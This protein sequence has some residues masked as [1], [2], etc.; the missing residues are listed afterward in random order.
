MP[1]YAFLLDID[2]RTIGRTT[3]HALQDPTL[4]DA[5]TLR[6][7]A[8]L[9]VTVWTYGATLV[10]VTVPD[11]R[12]E[13][14]NAVLTLPDLGALERS[15]HYVGST[16][17]R[18]ARCVVGSSFRVDGEQHALD[19]N[20]GRHHIHG[21]TFGFHRFVWDATAGTDGDDPWLRLDLDRPHGD[22]GYPGSIAVTTTYRL[23]ANRL[24]LEH[25][26]TTDR[27]T[28]VDVTN[29]AMWNFAGRGTIDG[30]LLAIN[31]ERVLLVDDELVP[32]G[33]PVPVAPTPFDFRR[34]RPIGVTAL[35]NCFVLDGEGWA[36]TLADPASGR[37]MRVV[38]DQP[39]LQVYTCDGLPGASR[40]AICLQTGSWP[41]SPNR[42]SFPSPVVRAGEEYR[43][44]TS[45]EFDVA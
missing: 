18:Y 31:S 43:H 29:H 12:G 41:D 11:R 8:G 44:V 19:A 4:V 37:T 25:C 36:A 5:Y 24:V 28:I 13:Q 1:L 17:G 35:D 34:P 33:D 20:A 27:T 3:G 45:H 2:R 7:S 30:H 21:G 32:I 26:A 39:G 22:Q 42:A 14:G 23:I 38:T 10:E 6:S 15:E 40:H 16:M 9:R